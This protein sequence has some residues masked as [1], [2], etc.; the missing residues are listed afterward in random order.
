MEKTAQKSMNFHMRTDAELMIRLD[1]LRR[2][3]PD[4][5]PR[6]EMIRR[7][8]EKACERQDRKK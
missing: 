3:E 2:R 5:P 7:L 4:V 8:I 6:A 1:D